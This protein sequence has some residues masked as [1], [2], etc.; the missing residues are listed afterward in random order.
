MNDLQLCGKQLYPTLRFESWSLSLELLQSSRN[1]NGSVSWLKQNVARTILF[2]FSGRLW[3]SKH[4]YKA[5]CGDFS[6]SWH[7]SHVTL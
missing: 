6:D 1:I 5:Y 3:F 2:L 7:E 4:G